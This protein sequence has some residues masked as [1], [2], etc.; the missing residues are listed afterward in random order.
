MILMNKRNNLL[1]ALLPFAAII[2]ITLISPSLEDFE[3]SVSSFKTFSLLAAGLILFFG[4]LFWMVKIEKDS[5][6]SAGS[7]WISAILA[8]LTWIFTSPLFP[9]PVNPLTSWLANTYNPYLPGLAFAFFAWT[10]AMLII[11]SQKTGKN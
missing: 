5:R 6:L 9:L 10:L 1:F 7:L 2:L 8:G 11:H 3:R 4:C